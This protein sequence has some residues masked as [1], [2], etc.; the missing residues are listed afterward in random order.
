MAEMAAEEI[1]MLGSRMTELEEE[2]KIALLP[3]DPLDEKNIMLEIR[4]GTGGDEAGIWCGD[5]VRMYMRYCEEQKWKA[6]MV[7]AAV[8]D[9]GGYKECTLEVTG[10]SVYSKLKWEAG[11]H[12]VQRVPATE[13]Q[14][15]VQT[16]TATVAV[17]PE[18]D[19]VEVKIDDK[20]IELTTA[21]SGG[22]GGQNVNKVETAVDLVHKPT[23]IRIFCTEERSQLKNR[24]RAMQILRSRLFE[25]QL[26]EQQKEISGRRKAQVGSGARSEK[27]RTYNW[28]DSRVSDHRVGQNF[29]LDNFLNGDVKLAIGA[30]QAMEQKEKLEDLNAEMNTQV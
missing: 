10:Q 8:A 24:I 13:S 30:C 23:G 18:V 11:V 5:L 2:L 1:E 4:A 22:A 19:E 26:E 17:M 9:N 20:D 16:S 29:P 12:R 6:T 27:I 25:L 28:K 14:G 15:R 3:K 21:R 7:S